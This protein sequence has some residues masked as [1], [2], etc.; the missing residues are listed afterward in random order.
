MHWAFITEAANSLAFVSS[1]RVEPFDL[2]DQFWK[3]I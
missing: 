1:S 2:V 3:K